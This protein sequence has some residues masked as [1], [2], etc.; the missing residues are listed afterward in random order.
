MKKII[1]TI[2]NGLLFGGMAIASGVEPG[3]SGYWAVL[4][5]CIA[6]TV[7]SALTLRND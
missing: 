2:I 3:S 6:I 1:G 5:L 7:N 4:G